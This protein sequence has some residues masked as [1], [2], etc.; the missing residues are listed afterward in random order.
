MMKHPPTVFAVDDNPRVLKALKHLLQAANCQ[1]Q[2]FQSPEAFL[3]QFNVRWPGCIICDLAMPNVNGL[4]LQRELKRRG[5]HMPIIFLTGHKSI[6]WTVEAMEE[7]AVAFLTKP[8]DEPK[9]LEQVSRAI[10]RDAEIRSVQGRLDVL[11]RR[12]REFFIS[13]AEGK[14]NKEIADQYGVT[15]R[16]VKFHRA[17]LKRKLEVTTAGELIFLGVQGGIIPLLKAGLAAEKSRPVR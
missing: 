17:N 8:I 12:E 6:P 2:V 15:L 7:G 14:M 16:T 1:V 13:I 4:A 3:A 11:T 9:L 5:S 10:R